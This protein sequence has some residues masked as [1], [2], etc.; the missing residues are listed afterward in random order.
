MSAW[1][2][3]VTRGGQADRS[4]SSHRLIQRWISKRSTD[5]PCGEE[6]GGEFGYT[7]AIPWS[8]WALHSTL[9]ALPLTA[10]ML[11]QSSKHLGIA[12]G[13]SDTSN[14]HALAAAK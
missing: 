10:T 11:D 14:V 9:V 7:M 8:Q 2:E 13:P 12:T 6:L 1:Q 5:S 4:F 3:H